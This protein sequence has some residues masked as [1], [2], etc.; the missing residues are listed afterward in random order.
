MN[1][2]R[3]NN[4]IVQCYG[5][6]IKLQSKDAIRGRYYLEPTNKYFCAKCYNRLKR[7]VFR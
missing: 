6:D 4:K 1:H 3:F 5:C 2:Q 7:K